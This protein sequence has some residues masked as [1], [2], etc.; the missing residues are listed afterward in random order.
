MYLRVAIFFITFLLASSQQKC[1][2]AFPIKERLQG[3][4]HFKPSQ[5]KDS[6]TSTLGTITTPKYRIKTHSEDNGVFGIL[7]IIFA[8]TGL[9]FPLAI[10][11]GEI[12]TQ[13]GRKFKRLAKLGLLLGLLEAV[14]CVFLIFYFFAIP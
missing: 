13:N 4:E 8:A 14:A 2:A 10:I 12:G 6:E 1:L 11:S 3:E 5:Q 7:A 9:L